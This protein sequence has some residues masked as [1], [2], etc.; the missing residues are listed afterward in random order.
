MNELAAEQTGQVSA[1][2]SDSEER[3]N[4]NLGLLIGL[5]GLVLFGVMGLLGLTMRLTQA[6][7]LGISD[8]W[9]YRIMTLHGAGMLVAALLAMMG[10]LWYFIREFVSLSVER[11]IASYISIVVGAVIVVV[12]V[13]F[14]GFATGWTFLWPLPYEP[15]GAWSEWAAVTF[16][17]GLAFVGI[18]FQI[19]CIDLLSK[20]S[21]RHG[22]I[23]GALGINFLRGRDDDP[24]K[25]PELA[26]IVV[27]L[28]GLFALAVGVTIIGA[29]L[30]RA[31][32]PKISINPLWAK[33]LTYFFGHTVM[34]LIIYLGAGIVYVLVPKFADRPW[35]TTRP[36]VIAWLFTTALVVTAYGHHLYMDF[37]QP[38]PVSIIASIASFG[39]ALPVAVVTVFT[40]MMLIW[41]SRYRWSLAS[42]L[43][44]LGFVGWTI[45]GVGAVI[46]SV[47]P[48][49]F[50]FHNTLW[51]PAHFHTYLLLGA[52]LWIMA[53]T[54]Y[55]LER[56]SGTTPT[57]IGSYTAP[58]LMTIG[59]L[60]LVGAWY[61]SGALGVPRRYAEQ[62]G[63]GDTYS[64]VASVFVVI[65]AIG[66]AVM[67]A[68]IVRLLAIALKNR[69]KGDMPVIAGGSPEAATEPQIEDVQPPFSNS[70]QIG[71]GAAVACLTLLS[72]VPTVVNA[73]EASIQ[74][75]HVDHT[76][77]FFL[78]AM[79]SI[80]GASI[81]S[82]WQAI[83]NWSEN[84]ALA[85]VIL[86]P[87]LMLIAMVPRFYGGLESSSIAHGAYHAIFLVLGIV[88]GLGAARLGRAPAW[89][90]II[91]AVTMG[92]L[93]AGGVSGGAGT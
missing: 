36:I 35:K 1:M 61:A 31:I 89:T 85:A 25:P 48:V 82:V 10:G 68:E 17:I 34:N 65:F 19:Y 16:L 14:G 42:S 15:L 44:Y 33:N 90:M 76:A 9:F 11:M 57:R 67:V 43:V 22:G 73:S 72:I 41:G 77:V 92:L 64:L 5:T 38:R 39:A 83:K 53:F 74:W 2:N 80:V 3:L 8:D 52:M 45:G 21:R 91:L 84:L 81:P 12:A 13:V 27:A 66:F 51:V 47:I 58:S 56:S 71:F 40:G 6:E 37:V 18:G 63:N 60:G 46:D 62:I 24:P 88:T 32:D 75:H 29:Q 87:A 26:A 69:R 86:A 93:Y 20:L 7:V 30:G 50:S 70:F 4:R 49:N 78:G 23:T 54:V 59:G 55:L 28:V 79:V